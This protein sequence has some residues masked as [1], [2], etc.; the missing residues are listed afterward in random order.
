VRAPRRS[1]PTEERRWLIRRFGTIVAPAVIL[2]TCLGLTDSVLA[3]ASPTDGTAALSRLVFDFLETKD[4]DTAENQLAE[5]LAHP[6][7]DLATIQSLVRQGHRFGREPVGSLPGKALSIHGR[8]FRYGLY[9]PPTYD[10][11]KPYA[12]VLCLHGA[13]FTGDAYLERWQTRLNDEYMIACPTL[14]QGNWWTREASELVM[15]TL[16]DVES[17]YH[18]DPDRV[19]LTGM[20]NGGI[21]AYLIGSHY[22]TVFAGL[23]P[24]A[25]GLDDVLIPFLENL[26]HTP[27]YIIH[28]AKD[29]VMP[30]QLSRTIAAELTR[31]G[32]PF[33]YREHD[34][35]HPIAGGHYFPREE[36]PDLVAWLTGRRRDPFPKRLTV[37]RDASHLLPFGWL[38]IDATDRIASFSDNLIDSRDASITNRVYA[39]IDAEIVGS[40]RIEVR[41]QRVKRYAL[42]LNQSLVDLT[43]P[44]TVVTNGRISFSGNLEP[45][46]E[47]LLREARHRHDPAM[48]F[49]ASLTVSVE[50][51]S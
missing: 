49:P 8:P 4:G 36:L 9:V 15:A 29:D 1:L 18:I 21:G 5:I 47:T 22:A 2:L 50:G 6:Q 38:R 12:L 7:A 48:L 30:V 10:R 19:F 25:S 45:S 43:K 39:K 44:V 40:N 35:T 11:A 24:M 51:D 27:L 14:P 32:Y 28:G 41:T 17:R 23:A 26:R 13:G 42:F 46:V 3:G 34:R 33:V 16:Q 20:S 31:L 37:V